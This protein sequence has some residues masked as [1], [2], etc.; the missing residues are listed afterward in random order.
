[1][2][3]V[4][5]LVAALVLAA[6]ASAATVVLTSGK[7]LDVANYTVR[8]TYV[9]LQYGSGRRESYPLSTVDL[10]ATRQANGDKAPVSA[11]PQQIGPRS[12]FIGAKSTGGTA[13][14]AITDSDVSHVTI[15]P[16]GEEKKP[17]AEPTAQVVLVSFEKR[18]VS[19]GQWDIVATVA[20]QGANAVQGVNGQVRVL[21][22]DGKTIASGAGSLLGGLAPG[23]QGTIT[24]RVAMEGEP[25][26]LA[27]DLNWQEIRPV[28]KPPGTPK[29]VATPKPAGGGTQAAA[30]PPPGWSIPAGASPNTLPSNMMALPPANSTGT[31]A[32]VPRE[33]PQG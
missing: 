5:T 32:Q 2:R 10:A 9:I 22:S 1:V 28:E 4:V 12:P 33:K 19:E 30:T 3:T 7:R 16:P 21:D 20:N 17:D 26:Q 31:G 29:P 18:K 23:K 15:P 27:V 13:A 6:E 24:A 11:A 25:V 14:V 8:G